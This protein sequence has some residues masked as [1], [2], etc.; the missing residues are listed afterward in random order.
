[1]CSPVVLITA[2]DAWRTARCKVTTGI[3]VGLLS[4][5]RSTILRVLRKSVRD[6]DSADFV[7]QVEIGFTFNL[8]GHCSNGIF[9]FADDE[10]MLLVNR[11]ADIRS[12]GMQQTPIEYSKKQRSNHLY[13]SVPFIRSG[14]D[15][16]IH[17]TV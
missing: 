10:C 4:F 8:T 2:D 6:S 11:E 14:N 15:L 9:S 13:G 3:V 7:T 5:A 12:Q 17:Y 16:D 1:M